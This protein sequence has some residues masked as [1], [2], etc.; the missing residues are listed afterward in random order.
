MIQQTFEENQD[1][2]FQNGQKTAKQKKIVQLNSAHIIAIIM[3]SK[4]I[5]KHKYH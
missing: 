1:T 2:Q 5:K 4:K 3:S